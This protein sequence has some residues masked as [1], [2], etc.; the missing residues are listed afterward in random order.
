LVAAAAAGLADPVVIFD[1]QRHELSEALGGAQRAALDEP[2]GSVAALL[3]EGWCCG[4][5]PTCIGLRRALRTG[6]RQREDDERASPDPVNP[7][8]AHAIWEG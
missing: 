7:Q 6:V 8:P 3:L 1:R 5:R 2:D 4:S